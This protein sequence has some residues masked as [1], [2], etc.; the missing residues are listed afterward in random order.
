MKRLVIFLVI[1]ITTIFLVDILFGIFSRHYVQNY[2][3]PGDY[4]TID[5]LIKD[6]KDDVIIIGS[7]VALN[8]AIPQIIEDSINMTVWNGAC[9]GQGLP[10]FET[11]LEAI[12]SHHKPDIILWGMREDELNNYNKGS[13]YNMLAPYYGLG[14][15]T[16]DNYIEEGTWF[17]KLMAKSNLYRYNTIWIRILLYNFIEPGEKGERGFIAKG[18]P[19]LPPYMIEETGDTEIEKIGIDKFKTIVDLCNKNNVE[20]ICFVP[21]VYKKYIKQS[22]ALEVIKQLCGEKNIPIYDALQDSTFINDSSLFFDNDHLNIEGA[23][24]FSYKLS[25]Y[26]RNISINN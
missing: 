13:R 10:Y 3:I 6:T 14:Y 24:I 12:F 5:Y 9:N 26:L 2:K 19:S 20:L 23:K 4:R 7:S 8:S 16:L 22:Q 21:P 11:M 18:I 1:I 15:K 25:S 17:D